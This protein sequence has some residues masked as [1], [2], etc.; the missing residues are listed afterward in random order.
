M[1]AESLI[2]VDPAAIG[3]IVGG[4][5][6]AAFLGATWLVRIIIKNRKAVARGAIAA[7][8]LKAAIAE[9]GGEEAMLTAAI[10]QF[11]KQQE[12]DRQADRAERTRQWERIE[13]CLA[14]AKEHA[15]A[16]WA[17]NQ[18]IHNMATWINGVHEQQNS[19]IARV[20]KNQIHLSNFLRE[21]LGGPT[22]W[23]SQA[24]PPTQSP[25]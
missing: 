3:G 9:N 1:A 20:E 13:E 18:S 25:A 22:A 10:L 23:P 17:I 15:Q 8:D 21:R 24:R 12:A 2:N 16:A 4:L 5:I 19:N 7:L 6:P 14:L 11:L